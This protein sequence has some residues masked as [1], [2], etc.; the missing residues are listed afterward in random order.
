MATVAHPPATC[1]CDNCQTE[2]ALISTGGWEWVDDGR[3]EPAPHRH[4]VWLL[5]DFTVLV[6]VVGLLWAAFVGSQ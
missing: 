3:A 4:P 6:F 2:R 5:V 1:L